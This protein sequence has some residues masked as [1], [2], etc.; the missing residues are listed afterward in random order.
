MV[1]KV[2]GPGRLTLTRLTISYFKKW[3]CKSYPP[4]S[5]WLT[6]EKAA[7]ILGIPEHKL[8]HYVQESKTVHGLLFN[9]NPLII[10]PEGPYRIRAM[11]QSNQINKE[12]K[13]NSA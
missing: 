4:Y 12:L 7:I 5:K 1:L 8:L 2:Q 3:G 6:I 11:I 9:K 10:H 13:I